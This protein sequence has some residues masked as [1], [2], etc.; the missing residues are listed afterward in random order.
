MAL[1]ALLGKVTLS[2]ASIQGRCVHLPVMT[3]RLKLWRTSY[4]KLKTRRFV[5]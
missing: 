1:S 5:L 3:L 4:V 2:I